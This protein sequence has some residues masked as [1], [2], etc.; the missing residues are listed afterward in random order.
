MKQRVTVV[1]GTVVAAT[2]LSTVSLVAATTVMAN[3]TT[4]S[5]F[6]PSLSGATQGTLAFYDGSGNAIT[7]GNLGAEP[8]FVKANTD[9]GRAGDTLG[10]L[11]AYTPQKGVLSANW[12]GELLGASTTYPITSGAPANLLNKPQAIAK[13]PFLWFAND[14]YP[15]LFPN[16]N[17]D[18]VWQKLYQLRLY[19]S[20]PGQGLDINR[21]ASATIAVDSGAGTWSQ[22]YP[23]PGATAPTVSTPASIS[24]TTRVGFEVTCDA[25]FT[26]ATLT[27]YKWLRAGTA[28]TGATTINYTLLPADYDKNIQCRATGSNANGSVSTTSPQ[29]KIGKGD[30]LVPTTNPTISGIPKPGK[31]LTTNPGVWTP[32][33]KSYKYQWFKGKN[34]ISGATSKTYT[35]LNGQVGAKLSCK[36]TAIKT[37]YTSGVKKTAGVTIVA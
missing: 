35:V 15:S 10:S 27:T 7:G 26:G 19:T 20:G 12:P 16:N 25:A 31:V 8:A 6:D 24:G 2:L 33:A 32:A 13:A 3:A 22:V 30:A 21:Y 37:G 34:A 29:E 11:Y 17:S 4:T 28:I 18:V 1:V 9:T 14:E 36:V 23:V 5:P